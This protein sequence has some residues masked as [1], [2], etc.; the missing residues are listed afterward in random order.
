LRLKLC[1]LYVNGKQLL[2]GDAFRSGNAIA[3][4]RN[5]R[6]TH[7]A[8]KE[9]PTH[10]TNTGRVPMGAKLTYGLGA[11]AYG[12]KDNGFSTFLLL[13]YNQVVGLP[14]AQVSFVIAIALVFDALIDPA[15]GVMSDRTHTK[16]GRR[17]PWLYASALPIAVTW[18]L[19]WHPPQGS[20]TMILAYLGLVAVL[21]RAAIA[22]NEVPSLAMAPEMTMDYHERT[23]VLRYRF[24]FGW[25]GGMAMLMLAYSV[26]LAPPM[27]AMSGPK[28]FGGFSAYGIFGGVV[29]A[30]AV[31]VSALGTHKLLAKPPAKRIEV[32]SFGATLKGMRQTLS[33][34]A[35]VILTLAGVFGYTNQYVG[36]AISQYNLNFVWQ[37]NSAQLI[38][39]SLALLSGVVIIFLLVT[40]IA[41]ALG[42]VRAASIL[43][44]LSAF[45]VTSSYWL[46]LAGVMPEPGDPALLPTFLVL[47]TT[48]T[49]LGVGAMIIGASMMSDVVEASQ[50]ETGRREEGLFFAGTLFMQKCASGVGIVLTGLILSLSDFPANAR[51][52]Q[53]SVD[54][55]DRY[56]MIFCV[57]TLTLSSFAALVFLRFPFGQ[58]EHDARVAKLAVASAEKG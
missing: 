6:A 50:E 41:H 16:W 42:K 47:N 20:Q 49:A 32:E 45:F 24:L 19:L 40:P 36:F 38:V 56:T 57:V 35:F 17:H 13:F 1:L 39:Y 58:A 18:M 27:G 8:C 31:L 2:G 23:V 37:L 9:E 21:A 3:V 46:R 4:D 29:M 48:G 52:G 10:M 26:F 25:I 11:V 7:R 55:I 22:T 44:F 53:V 33:N 34:R 54:V 15:L 43:T 30:L 5:P 28:A 51:A 14:A 12:I